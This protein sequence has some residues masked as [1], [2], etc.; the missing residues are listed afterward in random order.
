MCKLAFL[1][2]SSAFVQN[3]FAFPV[4]DDIN[5]VSI[6]VVIIIMANII[7]GIMVIIIVMVSI[8]DFVKIID[9]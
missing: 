9:I 1:I 2:L 4:A 6:V 3:M 7:I 5:Q 8:K